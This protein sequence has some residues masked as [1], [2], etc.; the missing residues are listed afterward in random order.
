MSTKKINFYRKI[1]LEIFIDDKSLRDQLIESTA[2]NSKA[3]KDKSDLKFIVNSLVE[4]TD[5]R[6]IFVIS[7]PTQSGKVSVIN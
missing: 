1:L 5:K 3:T 6:S 4:I 2:Q 7:G